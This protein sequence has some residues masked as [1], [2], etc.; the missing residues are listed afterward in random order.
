MPVT[1]TDLI[2]KLAKRVNNPV[3]AKVIIDHLNGA[4]KSLDGLCTEMDAIQTLLK[5]TN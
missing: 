5:A 3:Y 1:K 4:N 2:N